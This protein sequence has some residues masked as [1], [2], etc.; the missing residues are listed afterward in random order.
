M[1]SSMVVD[2]SESEAGRQ[3]KAEIVGLKALAK[4][5]KQ[6]AYSR[7]SDLLVVV[8]SFH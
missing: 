8:R 6:E 2:S 1:V 7:A 5:L 3:K 4:A